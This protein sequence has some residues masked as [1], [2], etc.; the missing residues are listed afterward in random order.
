MAAASEPRAGSRS[1]V[2]VTH[3]RFLS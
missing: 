1:P 2:G 3:D